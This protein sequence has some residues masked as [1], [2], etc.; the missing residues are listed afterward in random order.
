M[1]GV[2]LDRLFIFY[3]YIFLDSSL[4]KKAT[5][6][7]YKRHV[8]LLR[9]SLQKIIT[10]SEE[11]FLHITYDGWKRF[12]FFKKDSEDAEESLGGFSKGISRK[13]PEKPSPQLQ[14]D[15]FQAFET[16]S[17]LSDP[18]KSSELSELSELSESSD[19]FKSSELSKFSKSKSKSSKPFGK[20]HFERSVTSLDLSKWE[21]FSKTTSEEI[22]LCLLWCFIFKIP[23]NIS[24]SFLGMSVGTLQSNLSQSLKE[25][26]GSS[27]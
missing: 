17:E 27:V 23:E 22:L 2:N 9:P 26:G 25:L 3:F 20:K 10:L 19:P 24:A 8:K 13:F 7:V 11:N 16:S 12:A 18:F 4:A 6:F 15:F 5:F 21:A 1:V 14:T